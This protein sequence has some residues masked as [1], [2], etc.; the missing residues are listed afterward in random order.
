MASCVQ[1]DPF[2]TDGQ[3]VGGLDVGRKV[4]MVAQIIVPARK[5]AF[6]GLFVGG[7]GA[8]RCIGTVIGE[9]AIDGEAEVADEIIVVVGLPVDRGAVRHAREG[10][11]G[12]VFLHEVRSRSPTGAGILLR[13]RLVIIIQAASPEELGVRCG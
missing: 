7:D 6:C 4:K 2:E 8:H 9:H 12:P 1:T 11:Y 3:E 10:I 5:R 13:T